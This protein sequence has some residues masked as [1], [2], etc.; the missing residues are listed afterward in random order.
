MP[1]ALLYYQQA[2]IASIKLLIQPVVPDHLYPNPFIY[3]HVIIGF[4]ISLIYVT[5]LACCALGE[6]DQNPTMGMG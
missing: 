2:S 4:I 5:E 3:V 6:K 1:Q